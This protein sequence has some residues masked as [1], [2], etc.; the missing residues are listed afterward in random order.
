M[1]ERQYTAAAILLHWAIAL[2]IIAN[3]ALGWWMR[4]A[5]LVPGSQ[6]SAVVV[7]QVHKSLGLSVLAL[8]LLRLGLRLIYPVPG[9][10]DGMPT[11]QRVGATATHWLFYGLMLGLPLSG[12]L[13]VSSQW[14]D[15]APLEVPTL[16]FGL[17]EVPHL[18]GLH[19]ADAAIRDVSYGRSLM[20]HEIM[21]IGAAALLLLHVGAALKHQFKDRDGLLLRMLPLPKPAAA[22]ARRWTL[23]LGFAALLL[24]SL[25]VA[26][27]ALMTP[28]APQTGD[29]VVTSSDIRSVPGSWPVIASES[30]IEFA[31]SHA[32]S[33]F[34]GRFNRWQSDVDINLNNITKSRIVV[35]VETASA[36]DGIKLHDETLPGKEWFSVDAHPTSR[37]EATLIEGN[38]DGSYRVDGILT[39]KGQPI[40]ISGLRL[41][42][43]DDGARI[44][45][46]TVI[47]RAD[48]DLGMASDP[49]GSW[50]SMDIDLFIKSRFAPQ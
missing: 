8:S 33:P 10:P 17:F 26:Y 46:Q 34:R 13:M 11:W 47:N 40:A 41:T 18:F 21:A 6:A 50:V 37:Y 23:R 7:Y 35:T 3:L 39:I 48:A 4:D 15:G 27:Q 44:G 1:A 36:S 19:E 30:V 45:G 5:I 28:A 42:L 43:D 12:W 9:L 49:G 32:G 2:A 29:A 31:G 22:P 25:A 20:A 16:W 38:G 14:R 24:A